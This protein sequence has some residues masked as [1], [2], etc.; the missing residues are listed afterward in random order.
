MR[1]DW[2]AES[3]HRSGRALANDPAVTAVFA[4]NDQV[5]LGV[6]RAMQEAGR[7]VP[8]DVSFGGFDDIPEAPYAGPGLTSVRQGFT[9]L[10]ELGLRTLVDL[11]ERRDVPGG[12]VQGRSITPS[13]VVRDSTG[14]APLE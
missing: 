8:G 4:A 6:V 1:G 9:E 2:T 12:R 13:L 11:L 3:G 14:P 5:A 10:G 7:H